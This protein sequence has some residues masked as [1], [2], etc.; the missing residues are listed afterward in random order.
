MIFRLACLACGSDRRPSRT[1]LQEESDALGTFSRSG[2]CDHFRIRSEER[3][4]AGEVLRYQARTA[5]RGFKQPHVPGMAIW[6]V[7]VHVQRYF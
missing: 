2:I 1:V 6:Q 4:E 7:A 3:L 5:S